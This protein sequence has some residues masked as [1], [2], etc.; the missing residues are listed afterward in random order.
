VYYLGRKVGYLLAWALELQPLGAV[1][2][3][4][5]PE[6]SRVLEPLDSEEVFLAQFAR[7]HSRLATV[8]VQVNPLASV[9]RPALSENRRAFRK[10]SALAKHQA[11]RKVSLQAG[12]VERTYFL[13]PLH[14]A[15]HLAHLTILP[16]HFCLAIVSVQVGPMSRVLRP[17]LSENRQAF[18]K[19]WLPAG[20]VE[21]ASFL[22]PLHLAKHPEQHSPSANSRQVSINWAVFSAQQP[23]SESRSRRAIWLRLEV[24]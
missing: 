14:L 3:L 18:R 15:K 9:F 6:S 7:E 24:R 4:G 8:S 10:A 22:Q 23:Q 21:R 12:L 2:I 20:L 11:I 13:Q 5:S 16:E 1:V 19:V 17:A